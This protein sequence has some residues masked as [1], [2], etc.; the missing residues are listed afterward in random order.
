LLGKKCYVVGGGGGGGAGGHGAL[1]LPCMNSE[2]KPSNRV[3]LLN[4][5]SL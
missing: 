2:L 3:F 5:I 4:N 1:V